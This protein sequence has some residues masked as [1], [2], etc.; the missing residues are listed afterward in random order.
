M[1]PAYITIYQV[2]RNIHPNALGSA[3]ACKELTV[4]DNRPSKDL[5]PEN[6]ILWEKRPFIGNCYI[7]IRRIHMQGLENEQK[8]M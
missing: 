4:P 6:G 2:R 1:I 3:T 8:K 5:V 7:A